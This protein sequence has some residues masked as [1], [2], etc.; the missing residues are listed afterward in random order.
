[1]ASP[2][3]RSS[4]ARCRALRVGQAVL[5]AAV[6]EL[7]G[8][9]LVGG[10][11]TR[12]IRGG[13]LDTTMMAGAPDDVVYGMLAALTAAGTWLVVASRMGWP[14]STTHSIVGAIVGFGAV[15]MGIDAVQ[16]PLLV[17]IVLSWG[18]SPL[19]S[20]TLA[21]LIFTV[22]RRTVLDREDPLA[23]AQRWG[24]IWVFGVVVVITQTK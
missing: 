6:F 21:F 10:H 17:P 12:T 5:V 19:L 15:S 4:P 14:V 7:L 18:I 16:W 3:R 24:P 22:V 1:M 11:V 23:Q 8:A 20:G 2:R 13:I 9:F